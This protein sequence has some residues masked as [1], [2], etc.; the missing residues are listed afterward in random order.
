MFGEEDGFG[1]CTLAEG[2]NGVMHH[3]IVDSQCD[4]P[5]LL[6]IVSVMH[7]F[8]VD[9]QC[10]APPLLLIVSVTHHHYC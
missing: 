4:A 10:D 7:H 3:F 2:D 5:P 6:L 1:L 9:S 8:I